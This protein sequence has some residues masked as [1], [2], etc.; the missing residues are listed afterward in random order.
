MKYFFPLFVWHSVFFL[1]VQA[2]GIATAAKV[3]KLIAEEVV[4]LEQVRLPEIEAWKFLLV[5]AALTIFLILAIRLPRGKGILFRALFILSVWWGSALVLSVWLS[6]LIAL[7]VSTVAAFLWLWRAPLLL[8]NV[9][10]ILG[11]AGIA[12]VFGLRFAP[13]TIVFFLI[14]FSLYDVIAVYKTKHMIRLAKTML[15]VRAIFAVVAPVKISYFL[16]PLKN[17]APGKEFMILGGGD[18]AFP[19]MLASSVLPAA[20]THAVIVAG[21]AFLGFTASTL[22]FFFLGKKPMPALPPIAALSILGFLITKLI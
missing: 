22:L 14:A 16:A 17:V 1:A 19:L 2:L 13:E 11:I 21:F 12:S 5:F 20:L 9:L 6:D 7:I 18:L 3:Q 4:G 15:E 10:V 8:H